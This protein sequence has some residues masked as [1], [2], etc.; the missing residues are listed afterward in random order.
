[1]TATFFN[2]LKAE[3]KK[4]VSQIGHSFRYCT[5]AT[6]GLENVPRLR[7]VV[8]RHVSEGLDLTFYTDYRSKKIIH[9]KEN[10][11]VSLLFYDPKN[12]LQVQVEGLATTITDKNVLRKHWSDV[13]PNNRKDYIT[14]EPPG[15]TIIDPETVEY[16]ERENHFCMLKIEP[17]RIEYLKLQQPHHLRILFSKTE[18]NWDGEFLVP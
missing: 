5:L 6:I 1:M 12:R 10:S 16:L 11:Q 8:L 17:L 7:T 18:E 14:K 2:D 15:S 13:Q 9:I 3:L 4:G